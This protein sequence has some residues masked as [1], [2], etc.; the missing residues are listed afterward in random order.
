M[1]TDQLGALLRAARHPE[2]A[3]TVKTT[4]NGETTLL[5]TYQD[6]LKTLTT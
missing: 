3:Q 1:S 5:L 2:P 6:A 4:D